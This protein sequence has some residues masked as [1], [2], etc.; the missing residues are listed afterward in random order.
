MIFTKPLVIKQPEAS[1]LICD[2]ESA[3][4]SNPRT[5]S[6]AFGCYLFHVEPLGKPAWQALA[7]GYPE[8]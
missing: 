2:Q 4:W 5:I 1:S 8:N 6:S 3:R 7:D